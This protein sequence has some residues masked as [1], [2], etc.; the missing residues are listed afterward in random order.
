MIISARV[1]WDNGK[2]FAK[3][4]ASQLNDVSLLATIAQEKVNDQS[5]VGVDAIRDAAVSESSPGI[6]PV[7]TVILCYK[8]EK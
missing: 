8:G 1:A 2:Y 5:G 3:I 6:I 7:I 4:S